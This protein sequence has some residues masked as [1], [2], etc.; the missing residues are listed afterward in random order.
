MI[1]HKK[2]KSMTMNLKKM[3]I[4]MFSLNAYSNGPLYAQEVPAG[5]EL[6]EIVRMGEYYRNTASL[7]FD[8]QFTFADSAVPATILETVTGSY[9]IDYDKY[10][11]MLDST[12]F[13]Q[14]LQYNLVIFHEDKVISVGV[15]Q[16]YTDVLRVPLLDSLFRL[17]QVLSLQ[18]THL[19]DTTRRLVA[20]FSPT[21]QY[22]GYSIDYDL[23]NYVVRKIN[24]YIKIPASPSAG[25]TSLITVNFT[26]YRHETVQGSE[27]DEF[28]FIQRQSGQFVGV[29]P[30]ADY[31]VINVL[32]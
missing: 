20:T 28:R 26:N 16:P 3:L 2:F 24:Y 6:M 1:Y 7:R 10:H 13:V 25:N 14:G 22:S 11:I 27:F 19:N 9:T 31:R 23:R 17:S 5:S 12:E 30:Y 18:V 32:Q 15:K 21:A 29:P 8:V 4:L